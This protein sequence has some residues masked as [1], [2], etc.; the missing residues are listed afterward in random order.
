[1]NKVPVYGGSGL[2]NIRRVKSLTGGDFA[3]VFCFNMENHWGTHIDAPYHFFEN[4][5]KIIDYP[6][7][8]WFF[9]SPQ[10]IKV[11]LSPAEI[12]TCSEWI[13]DINPNTDIL[14]FQSGWDRF[15]GQEIYS[16]E[17]PGIH[18]EVGFFLR[19]KYP[20]IR[21]IGIDWIS[22]SPYKNRELGRESHR[23]FLGSE[24]H[25][26]PML[27][28]E[29]MNM[30]F[31]LTMLRELYVMPLMVDAFDSAPCTIIGAFND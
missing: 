2:L 27:L 5:K 4:G 12:L 7:R 13:K 31:D 24:G 23:V 16:Q 19:E 10:V 9:K 28:I 6:P 17:N 15:R 18:P 30:S 21:A 11:S 1:M 22:I 25:N 14:L 8:Y 26:N 3:N 20:E 29:D